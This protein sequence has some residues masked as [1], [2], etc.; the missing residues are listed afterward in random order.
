LT[1]VVIEDSK[2]DDEK[3]VKIYNWV[4]KNFKYVSDFDLYED[5]DYWVPANNTFRIMRGDC[6][7][8]AFL[9][10]SMLLHAGV[11]PENI[12]TYCGVTKNYKNK[13]GKLVFSHFSGHMWTAY[14]RESDNEWIHLDWTTGQMIEDISKLELMRNQDVYAK[15]YI[16]FNLYDSKATAFEDVLHNPPYI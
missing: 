14:R 7:D 2:S 3:V 9:I 10:H 1:N 4:T 16:Y 6:E 15:A 8:G 5:F 12:R 11:R 13:N